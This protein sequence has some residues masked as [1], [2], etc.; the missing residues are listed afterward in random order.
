MQQINKTLRLAGILALCINI[1]NIGN[2]FLDYNYSEYPAYALTIDIISIVLTLV[3]GIFYLWLCKKSSEY[4]VKRKAIF[5]TLLWL[6]I[7]N[8]LFVW[9]ISLWVEIVVTGLQRKLMFTE[10]H[11]NSGNGDDVVLGENSYK[12]K[13]ETED[14]SSGL[15][16][17]EEL[18]NKGTIT[19]E[20]YNELRQALI[21]K[22]LNKQ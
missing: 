7:L 17:L 10:M 12:V 15:N 18:K 1:V 9:I 13:K 14:L 3:T 16:E 22:F 11:D 6:N 2:L 8:N 21:N 19:E 4:I 5:V 20:E